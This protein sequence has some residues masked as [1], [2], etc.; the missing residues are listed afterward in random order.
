MSDPST[1]KI[2]LYVSKWCAHSRSVERF[3]EKNEIVVDKITIDGDEEAR[4]RL[5][6]LNNGYASVPTLLL[7]DGSVLTEPSLN[8]LRRKLG[9]G[10]TPRLMGRIRG[11]LNDKDSD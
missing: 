7:A 8:E 2:T 9:L 5:I 1:D 10:K 6:E 3:L 4:A 11:I